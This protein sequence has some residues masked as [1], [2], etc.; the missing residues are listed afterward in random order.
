VKSLV[1][2][3]Q[4]MTIQGIQLDILQTLVDIQT[5]ISLDEVE[6]VQLAEE[7]DLD[8]N[9]VRSSLDTLAKDGYVQL[10]KIEMLA[11]TAYSAFATDTGRTVLEESQRRVSERLQRL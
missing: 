6:D 3:E 10:D 8:L 4:I 7:A 2:K 11:G 9:I 1:S 5:A